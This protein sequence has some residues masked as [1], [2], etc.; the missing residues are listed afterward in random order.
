MSERG[1]YLSSPLTIFKLSPTGRGS[2][3]KILVR[4]LVGRLS[5]E[6][7][8][9]GC[10]ER[11]TLEDKVSVGTKRPAAGWITLCPEHAHFASLAE[12]SPPQEDA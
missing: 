10:G 6:C 2:M 1:N 7:D 8:F 3:S 4:H 12:P 9:E 11:W 5:V